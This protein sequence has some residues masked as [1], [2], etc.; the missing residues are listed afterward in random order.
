MSV[1]WKKIEFYKGESDREV[2]IIGARSLEG[3]VSHPVGRVSDYRGTGDGETPPMKKN[4]QYP[5]QK[6]V[7]ASSECPL[8]NFYSLPIKVLAPPPPPPPPNCY[9]KCE[10]E[11]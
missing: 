5:Y 9:L 8:Q 3:T 10:M 4:D 6:L 2:M 1:L 7:P 11:H